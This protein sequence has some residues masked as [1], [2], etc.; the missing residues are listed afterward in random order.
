MSAAPSKVRCLHIALLFRLIAPGCVVVLTHTSL[1]LYRGSLQ[2]SPVAPTC[3]L[4]MGI[5]RNAS[6]TPRCSGAAVLRFYALISSRSL[7]RLLSGVPP[8]V[9][10][11]ASALAYRGS[12]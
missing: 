2:Q 3:F 1:S 4:E 11:M 6:L 12:R 9:S 7:R 5:I 8:E 10:T